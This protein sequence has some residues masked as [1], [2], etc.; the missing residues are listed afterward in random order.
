MKQGDTQFVSSYP[1]NYPHFIHI[2]GDF[3]DNF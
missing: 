2:W 1:H 3:V